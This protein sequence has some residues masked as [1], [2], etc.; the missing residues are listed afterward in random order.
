MVKQF[1]TV[2]KNKKLSNRLVQTRAAV[3]Q[4][5][6][7]ISFQDYNLGGEKCL[8]K[9]MS[10][11]YYQLYICSF[12]LFVTFLQQRTRCEKYKSCNLSY[13][14]QKPVERSRGMGLSIKTCYMRERSTKF[15][16]YQQI[17]ELRT[18]KVWKPR[19]TL[20]FG[21]VSQKW[22]KDYVVR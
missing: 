5:I 9:L 16:L 1:C 20:S 3:W 18:L 12:S 2:R 8:G 7:A 6:K 14:Y 22:R 15:R 13:L 4:Q 17:M 10:F 11:I 19:P 21:E